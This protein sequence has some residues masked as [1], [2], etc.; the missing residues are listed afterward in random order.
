MHLGLSNTVP[1]L[2]STRTCGEIP[3]DGEEQ[4]SEHPFCRC[5]GCSVAAQ[6]G[7]FIR[8]PNGEGEPLDRRSE[9]EEREGA[10]PLL[11]GFIET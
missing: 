10:R 1:L 3:S 11:I 6:I 2:S 8:A 7:S 4:K 5:L 9:N